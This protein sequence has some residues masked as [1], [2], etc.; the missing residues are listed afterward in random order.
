MIRGA[1]EISANKSICKTREKKLNYAQLVLDRESTDSH[2]ACTFRLGV[3]GSGSL[4]LRGKALRMTLR[5]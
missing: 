5:I 1:I 2:I 4:M 3:E